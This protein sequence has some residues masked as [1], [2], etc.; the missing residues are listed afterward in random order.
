VHGGELVGKAFFSFFE[1]F[2]FTH[3]VHGGELVGKHR[4][5]AYNRRRLCVGV[6]VGVCSNVSQMCCQCV[7]N[8]FECVANVLPMYC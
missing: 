1:L 7:A 5:N 4:R 8:V 3:V 6:G 2:F